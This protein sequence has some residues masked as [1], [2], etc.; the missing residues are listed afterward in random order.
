MTTESDVLA[1][2]DGLVTAFGAH[3]VEA[4]FAAFRDDATF[5]FYTHDAR[6]ESRADYEQLWR[7][8]ESEDGFRVLSCESSDQRVQVLGDVAVFTHSV[9]THVS[10][11]DG[12]ESVRERETIV[13]AR[14]PG[15]TGGRW[16]AV[17]E[18]LSPAA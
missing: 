4:Y 1:A 3:D 8:W 6:L 17:H 2:A 11:H 14:N 7:R 9:E 5:V 16:L 12:Q 13:F 18:H 10:T 15:D